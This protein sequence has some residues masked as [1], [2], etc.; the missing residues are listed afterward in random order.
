MFEE[1]CVN[2]MLDINGGDAKEVVC[3]VVGVCGGILG[4]AGGFLGGFAVATIEFTPIV[5]VPVGIGCA[6][7][8]AGLGYAGAKDA[9]E[10]AWDAIANC[11]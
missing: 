2:E 10:D 8:G 7:V 5:G 9:A 6:V 1:L 4:A 3:T 11:F